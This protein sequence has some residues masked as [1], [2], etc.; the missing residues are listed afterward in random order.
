MPNVNVSVFEDG[1]EVWSDT[2]S[3]PLEIGRQ[4]N[5]DS[6]LLKVQNLGN[7]FRIAIAPISTITLPREAIRVELDNEFLKLSNIHSK[8]SF[9]VGD[10]AT[11][12]PPGKAS[13]LPT[14]FW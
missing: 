4:R 9:L 1:K 8:I 14:R 5:D 6:G 3:L 7:C 11:P 2:A 10:D 13:R 12:L